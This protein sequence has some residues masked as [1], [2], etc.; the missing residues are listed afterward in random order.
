MADK[1]YGWNEGLNDAL[2]E[3]LG[4]C[5]EEVIKEFSMERSVSSAYIDFQKL[6]DAA[7]DALESAI[8]GG[9]VVA[10]I[11]LVSALI[12][13]ANRE[14]AYYEEIE[15]AKLIFAEYGDSRWK[16]IKHWWWRVSALTE[17][18][19]ILMRAQRLAR[20]DGQ[21]KDVARIKLLRGLLA[22][23]AGVW[24]EADRLFE[25]FVLNAQVTIKALEEAR[26]QNEKALKE[27]EGRLSTIGMDFV[28]KILV[29][30][31]LQEAANSNDLD[32]FIKKSFRDLDSNG[33]PY[34]T[35]VVRRRLEQRN[36]D[37]R[38]EG[39]HTFIAYCRY[40]P[41]LRDK[42]DSRIERIE[43]S[44]CRS[45]AFSRLPERQRASVVRVFGRMR[46]RNRRPRLESMQ[47]KAPLLIGRAR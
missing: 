41:T 13:A 39:L 5:V 46:R 23:A 18:N 8:S 21:E 25:G 35:A 15:L 34:V 19:N 47:K 2:T 44:I 33:R 42:I 27:S 10:S 24:P 40:R 3:P 36:I 32:S 22:Q 37:K 29:K 16:G 28:E 20:K 1:T 14:P 9:L 6:W 7:K 38:L 4:K 43:V 17:A 30:D 11:R 12:C 45:Y 26:P 31:G